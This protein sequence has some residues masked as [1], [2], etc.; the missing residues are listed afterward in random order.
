MVIDTRDQTQEGATGPVEKDHGVLYIGIDLGTSRTAIACSNGVRESLASVIGY[1]KDVVSRKH[2]KKDVLFGQEAFDHRLSVDFYR[3]LEHGVIKFSDN[4]G[5]GE[6][7]KMN[8]KAAS[9]LVRHAVALAAPRTD[10]LLYGVIGCPA[11]A[12]IHNRKAII[13]AARAVIDSVMICSEPF[14]VAYGLDRL[15]D[16]LVIDIGAGTTDLCRMHG[17]M[18]GAEDQI[19]LKHAGDHIDNELLARVRR[20][21]PKAQV[22]VNMVRGWKERWSSVRDTIEPIKVKIPIDGKP[23]EFDVTDDVRAA[24]RAIVPP[25]VDGL[26]RLIATCDPEFQERLKMNVLLGGG[27]SQIDGL[28]DEIEKEM[29]ARLGGGS[30]FTVEEPVYGGANGALKIA[31]DMPEEY[32]ERLK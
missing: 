28:G 4:G 30:V 32:W 18:P 9:D 29:L 25:I 23:A 2:L 14:A 7:G 24:C 10:E 16:V 20:R 1:P 8:M 3:P 6:E 13:D 26:A 15:S 21:V 31:H 5:T 11:Q 19:T 17:T 22:N 12:S 27:G